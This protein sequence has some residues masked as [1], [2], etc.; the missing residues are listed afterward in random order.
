MSTTTTTTTI[1]TDAVEPPRQ[2]AAQFLRSPAHGWSVGIPGAIGEFIYDANEPVTMDTGD[3]VL[4]AITDRG[5]IRINLS[6]R[7]V[8]VALEGT[9]ECTGGWTQSVAFCVPE[10][11]G[12]CAAH[13]VLTELGPDRGALTS[14]G[15]R[16]FLFDL[17]L[18]SRQVQFCVR[19]GDPA[20]LAVLR[21]GVGHSI[22]DRKSVV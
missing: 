7:T 14:E 18:G 22:L 20:L 10:D 5:A 3:G 4:D 2:L 19:T 6:H 17:G 16:E 9:G 8:C 21:K 15:R 13:S 1:I 11:E 12:C